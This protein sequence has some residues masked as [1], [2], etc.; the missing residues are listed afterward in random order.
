MVTPWR[1]GWQLVRA[2]KS[3]ED[4]HLSLGYYN[5]ILTRSVSSACSVPT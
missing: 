1:A 4:A 5:G 3:S 2:K